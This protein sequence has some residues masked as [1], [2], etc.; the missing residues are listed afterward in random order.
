MFASTE[1]NLKQSNS[2]HSL[3]ENTEL[4][5]SLFINNENGCINLPTLVVEAHVIQFF[6]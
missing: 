3:E 5:N 4:P 6:R 2:M 1:I